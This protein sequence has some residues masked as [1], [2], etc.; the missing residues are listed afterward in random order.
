MRSEG[1]VCVSVKSHITS[2]ASVR[3]EYADTYSAGNGGPKIC[4]V[5]FDTATFKSY[6][7]VT[8]YVGTAAT[9]RA[10]FRRQILLSILKKANNRLNAT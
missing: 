3:P 4:G 2:G 6:G 1:Y 7:T 9:F 10:L 8:S 5:F